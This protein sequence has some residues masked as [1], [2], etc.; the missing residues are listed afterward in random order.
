M[1]SSP[2]PREPIPAPWRRY[3]REF[4]IECLPWVAFAVFV[5]ITGVLWE[6]VIMPHAISEPSE[7][8]ASDSRPCE[9]APVVEHPRRE[10]PAAAQIITN[11]LG[12]AGSEKD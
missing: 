12:E 7:T 6:N 5:L 9:G 10:T 8:P 2:P 11:A 1:K 3:W 4:R